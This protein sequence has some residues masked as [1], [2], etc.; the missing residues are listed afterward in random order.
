MRSFV[1]TPT[2][3]G[4]QRWRRSSIPQVVGVES[5]HEGSPDS[6][7][8]SSYQPAPT[9]DSSVSGCHVHIGKAKRVLSLVT[10]SPSPPLLPTCRQPVHPYGG[11]IGSGRQAGKRL[12]WKG[13]LIPVQSSHS[14][15]PGSSRDP[16]LSPERMRSLTPLEYTKD[17]EPMKEVEPDW[18]EWV[19]NPYLS[20]LGKWLAETDLGRPPSDEETA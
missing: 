11:I 6:N 2:P 19:P 14:S 3:S 5:S 15:Q 4:V 8:R 12:A 16:L 18:K 10:R 20:H 9:T 13:V 1:R 17:N 7:I